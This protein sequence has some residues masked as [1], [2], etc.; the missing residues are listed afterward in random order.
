L[1]S[2]SIPST[3][4]QPAPLTRRSRLVRVGGIGVVILCVVGG[5]L[6]L[7]GWFSPHKLTP[8]RFVDGFEEVYGIHSG[9]RRNHGKGVCV[10]GFFDSNG[11]GVRLSKAVVFK[12]G[13][14]LVIGRFSQG[15]G[16]P[17]VGDS[18]DAV[19]GL[20]LQFSLPDGEEWRAA[21]INMPVF[22]FNTPQAFYDH[23]LASQ[24]DP[25]THKPDPEKMAAFAASH[26]E[27][28]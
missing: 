12:A 27:F 3:E 6:Y 14:V 19:R 28:V 7:G 18:P 10:S 24:P 21:M 16:N 23:L 1:P 22:P 15:G 9:F 4:E 11:Q 13:R 26:P 2:D 17:Y 5:F 25:H 8:A 20:G